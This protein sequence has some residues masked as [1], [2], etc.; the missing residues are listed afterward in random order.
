MS[1]L[2][3]IEVSMKVEEPVDFFHSYKMWSCF[4]AVRKYYWQPLINGIGSMKSSN[5]TMSPFSEAETEALEL[6]YK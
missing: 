2:C 1:H 4:I 6:E 3:Y 5:E